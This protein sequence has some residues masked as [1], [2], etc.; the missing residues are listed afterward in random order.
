MNKN[1]RTKIKTNIMYR[2]S[3]GLVDGHC[4]GEADGKLATAEFERE[5]LISR[6]KVESGNEDCVACVGSSEHANLNDL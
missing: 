3:L 4:K 5:E 2:L 6:D 1:R